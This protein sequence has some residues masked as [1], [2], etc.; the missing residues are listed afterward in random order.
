M[1]QE[2]V[3]FSGGSCD[4]AYDSVKSGTITCEFPLVPR[5]PESS[6]GFL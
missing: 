2:G 1:V 3:S 6:N 5:V 4:E